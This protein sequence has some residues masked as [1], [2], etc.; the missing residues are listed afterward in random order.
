M[1]MVT[2]GIAGIIASLIGIAFAWYQA[3]FVLSQDEGTDEM[4]RIAA[5][6]QKGAQAFLNREYR[7]IGIFVAGVTVV[8]VILSF[9][10]DSFTIWT[11]VA[12]V[13]GAFA[14]GLAGYIGMY[15]AVRANVRTAQA[16]SKSLN[17]GLR[18]AFSGGTVMG[19]MVVALSPAGQYKAAC[20]S[21]ISSG[22]TVSIVKFCISL[23][24]AI[25]SLMR[26]FSFCCSCDGM[27]S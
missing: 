10:S 8:L 7:A 4:K 14:S 11:A 26:Y 22:S 1:T 2:A 3:N 21:V 15:I 16:A 6:I 9:L 18:V 23:I 25:H 20:V 12:F 13:V 19:T 24:S 27:L 5:A 17:Q